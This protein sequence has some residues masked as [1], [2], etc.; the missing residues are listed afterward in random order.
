ME[1][2]KGMKCWIISFINQ[3]GGCGKSTLCMSI[4]SAISRRHRPDG[5]QYKVLVA[6][7]D[8]QGTVLRW[9]SAAPDDKPLPFPVINLNASGD[10]VHRELKKFV[11]NYDFIL[12]DTP[13]SVSTIPYSALLVS[14]LALMPLI[15]SP[16][17]LWSSFETK[18]VID[19]VREINEDLQVRLVINRCQSN[20]NVSKE[21][22]NIVD[23]LDMPVCHSKVSMLTAFG[24]AA[25]A[26]TSIYDC[27][28]ETR[29]AA[30]L[31]IEDLVDEVFEILGVEKEEVVN[32]R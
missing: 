2:T 19:N 13:A 4:A 26:G 29:R 17:D 23:K 18:P 15:P 1:W 25:G 30:V 5:V 14:D 22:L 12:V 9:S 32:E 16:P 10:K 24:E 6:S 31:Q 8:P 21:I 11:D 3:K 20:L 7:A 27:K 28:Y